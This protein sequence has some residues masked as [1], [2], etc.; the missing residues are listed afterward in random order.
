MNKSSVDKDNFGVKCPFCS[1]TATWSLNLRWREQ[2]D[3]V[4][5]T[6]K[7]NISKVILQSALLVQ[8]RR[9]QKSLFL[10]CLFIGIMIAIC[11]FLVHNFANDLHQMPFF[12]VLSFSV[13]AICCSLAVA[14]AIVLLKQLL[15]LRKR[16]RLIKN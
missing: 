4:C 13:A 9:L 3:L 12:A 2:T 11:L 14:V 6:C 10:T 15:F 1:A 8:Q 16:L 7:Q 5:P